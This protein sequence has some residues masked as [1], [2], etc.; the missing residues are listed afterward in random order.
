MAKLTSKIIL[1]ADDFFTD[2]RV[3]IC[4]AIN[5]KHNVLK[6]EQEMQCGLKTIEIDEPGI[7][8]NFERKQES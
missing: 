3:R 7:C 2:T 5:C 6:I 1:K 8:K 4:L